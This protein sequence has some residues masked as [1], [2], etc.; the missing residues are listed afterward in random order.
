MPFYLFIYLET[1]VSQESPGCSGT[2]YIDRAGFQLTKIL[3]PLP[4]E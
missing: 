2:Q 3:L 4:W 1:G